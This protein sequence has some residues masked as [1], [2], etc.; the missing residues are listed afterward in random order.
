MKGAR[1]SHAVRRQTPPPVMAASGIRIPPRRLVVML[2]IGA[3]YLN[4]MQLIL[5][6]FL[7]P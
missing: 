7:Y 3:A 5:P 2:G 6:F 1:F 4:L